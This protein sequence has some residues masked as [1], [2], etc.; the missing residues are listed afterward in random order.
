MCVLDWQLSFCES[1]QQLQLHN[2][3]VEE[4]GVISLVGGE[5]KAHMSVDQ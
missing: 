1:G 5:D 4:L 3:C 2:S